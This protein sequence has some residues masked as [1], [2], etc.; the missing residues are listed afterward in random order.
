MR[1]DAATR[2][3]IALLLVALLPYVLFAAVGCM[4]WGV[5]LARFVSGGVGGVVGGSGD[6]RPALLF[7]LVL[8]VGT[9][10]AAT[11]VV[12]Q[13][14]ATRRLEERVAA[15]VLP[16]PA[17]LAAAAAATRLADRLD[18]VDDVERFSFTYGLS[19]PRVVVSRGLVEALSEDELGAVLFHERYHVD[20]L[21]PLKV[22]VARAAST[23][24]FFLPAVAALASRYRAGRELAADR[25]AVRA[26]GPRALAGALYRLMQVPGWEPPAPAAA[27]GGRD[28]L[29]VR[30]TQ[31]E[32]GRE[33]LTPVPRITVGLTAA[34]LVAL[35]GAL[36]VTVLSLGGPGAM[37]REAR[38]LAGPEPMRGMPPPWPAL[39][40]LLG[41]TLWWRRSRGRA[42]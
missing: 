18:L 41:L 6:L 29:D 8:V 11:S 13:V 39:L 4:L 2:S 40:A 12:R 9:T 31:L 22:L 14:R 28:L 16:V 21:D 23:A 3:F 17:P 24:W 26:R 25:R 20:R 5:V 33:P 10:L 30:L 34:A 32:T 42:P 1:L 19:R 35:A 36:A 27:V 38:S 15:L 37:M 7:V